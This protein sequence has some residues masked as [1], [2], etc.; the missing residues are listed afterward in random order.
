MANST[1]LYSLTSDEFQYPWSIWKGKVNFRPGN[2]IPQ[3]F[4]PDGS[5]CWLA[6]LYLLKGFREGKS[7]RNGGGTLLTWAKNLTP[8]IRWCYAH[9]CDFFDLEDLDF[10]AFVSHIKDETMASAPHKKAR[11]SGQVRTIAGTVMNFLAFIDSIM[12]GLNLIGPEGKVT[13][14]LKAVEITKRG[15]KVNRKAWT[16]ECLPR[17]KPSRR[18]QPISTKAVDKLY[19]ANNA[20]AV[21]SYVMRRRFIM[22]RLFELTGGR[23]VEASLVKVKDLLE[24][25]YTGKL[26]IFSAKQQDDEAERF[27]PVTKAD[28][29]EVLSFVKHYRTLI[30]RK[31]IGVA[32]DHGYLFVSVDNGK[33][34]QVDTLTAELYA[35]R[36]L[37]GID[38]EEACL[39]A[40]R[41]RYITNIFRELI[42]THRCENLSD[43]KKA[44]LS[45]ETLKQQVMEWTGHSSLE[46]LERYIHLAFE[47]ETNFKDSLDI[48]QASKVVESLHFIIKDYR[49]Q[50][51]AN[52]WTP[53]LFQE[54]GNV[55]A[56]A[57]Q[58]LFKLFGSQKAKEAGTV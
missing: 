19:D 40:F 13:A 20:S 50:A 29:K 55:V 32:N 53:K 14:T 1:K 49:S 2:D 21:S 31:T 33:H 7:R 34:L 41:H 45:M 25:E 58:E 37:A 26:R 17:G 4:W 16:H 36:K 39:H 23:R 11:G 44:L 48:L 10:V 46:S 27:V 24:A 22:L 52:G 42:R 6:N 3:L 5:V 8:F 43:L 9:E 51:Q 57:E 28:L 38:D 54:F 18:R 56:A 35:I 47:V 12:P 15:K 30:I